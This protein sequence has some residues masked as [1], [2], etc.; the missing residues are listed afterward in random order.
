MVLYIQK[1]SDARRSYASIVNVATQF[2]GNRNGRI[3]DLDVDCLTDF[4]GDFYAGCDVDPKDVEYVETY[5]SGQ[6]HIDKIELEALSRVY[7]KDRSEPLRIGSVKS[8]AGHSE[9]SAAMFGIAK[10][11]I[12]LDS[13]VIPKNINYEKPNPEI[14]QLV[15][16]RMEVVKENEQ[17]KGTYVA[18]NAI[19][20]DSYYGHALFKINPKTKKETK[21]ELP[22]LVIASTRTEAGINELLNT[23]S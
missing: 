7:C 17:F 2:N 4:L 12:A 13:G 6:K 23:V 5:G 3:L 9:A 11:L 16:G 1:A 10:A 19:G 18:V 8:N 22:R 14:P 15:D 20:L 21:D